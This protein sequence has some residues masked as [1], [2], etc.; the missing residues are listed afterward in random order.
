MFWDYYGGWNPWVGRA[1]KSSKVRSHRFCSAPFCSV[2]PKYQ[3]IQ[4]PVSPPQ[5]LSLLFATPFTIHQQAERI[6]QFA[7]DEFDKI[8]EFVAVGNR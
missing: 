5:I 4:I 7:K 6:E 3:N 1:E 2:Y 8:R